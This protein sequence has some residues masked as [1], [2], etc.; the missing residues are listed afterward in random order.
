MSGEE[1][2]NFLNGVLVITHWEAVAYALLIALLA[3]FRLTD[4]CLLNT[5]SFAFYWGFKGLLAISP[6][7]DAWTGTAVVV[8]AAS[9]L[10]MLILVQF[11]YYKPSWGLPHGSRA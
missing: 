2:F 8:Y 4:S 11:A 10:I 5:F 9:G 7:A 6:A 1:T 3:L